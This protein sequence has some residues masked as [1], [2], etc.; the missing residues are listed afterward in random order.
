M[1]EEKQLNSNNKKIRIIILGFNNLTT[2]IIRK[3]IEKSSSISIICNI[4]KIT[5]SNMKHFLK[6]DK[7]KFNQKSDSLITDLE[8]ANI[9][10]TDLFFS[11]T[12]N[13]PVNL[14]AV[15]IVQN[16]FH[17]SK[18]KSICVLNNENLATIYS[19]MELQ[20]INTSNLITDQILNTLDRQ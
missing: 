11:V 19:A 1:I 12:K 13:D 17:L 14:M 9:Q 3:F 16:I 7:I 5:E 18:D 4:Q 2:A 8:N 6:E 10:D 15:Q 20:C